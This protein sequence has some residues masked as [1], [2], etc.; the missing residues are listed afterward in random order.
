MMELAKR[1]VVA[2]E[3]IAET[4]VKKPHYHDFVT[5]YH[6]PNPNEVILSSTRQN[7]E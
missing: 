4:L 3:R 6:S 5:H 2:L 7:S 1:A